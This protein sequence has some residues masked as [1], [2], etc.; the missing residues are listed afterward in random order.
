[1]GQI[2]E[3]AKQALEQGAPE[4]TRALREALGHASRADELRELAQSFYAEPEVAVP[5]FE[6]LLELA[7][8]DIGARVDLGFV[9]FLMGEDEEAQRQLVDCPRRNST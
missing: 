8:Q 3:L 1:M 5:T 9:Y 4:A 2:E 7:P 6:R